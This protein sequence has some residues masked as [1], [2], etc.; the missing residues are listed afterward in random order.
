MLRDEKGLSR[1]EAICLVGLGLCVLALLVWLIWCMIGSMREG[2]DTFTMNTAKSVAIINSTGSCLVP[3]CSGSGIN[4]DAKHVDL[5]GNNYAFFDAIGNK[6][7]EDCP[8]GYNEW[9]TV[10][11][12]NGESLNAGVGTMVIKASRS[13]SSIDVTLTW[14]ATENAKQEAQQVSD[15]QA[16]RRAQEQAQAEAEEAARNASSNA[17]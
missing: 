3:G 10:T 13:G 1:V 5:E 17:A 16:E 9:I 14:V 8:E 15:A 6:M 4:H 7:V 12:S 2:D 11:S